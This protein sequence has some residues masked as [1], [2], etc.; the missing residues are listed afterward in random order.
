MRF[1]AETGWWCPQAVSN[2]VKAFDRAIVVVQPSPFLVIAENLEALTP[3]YSGRDCVKSLRLSYTGL[4]LQRPDLKIMALT[5]NMQYPQAVSNIVNA[6]ARVGTRNSTL[7][8]HM[9]AV[10]LSIPLRSVANR[11]H[12]ETSRCFLGHVD[13]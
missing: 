6:F 1:V 3:S 13:F 5:Q 2:V 11:P 9:A 7:F 8:S 4:Y 10:V 12:L